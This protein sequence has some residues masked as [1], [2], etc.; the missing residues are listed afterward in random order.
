LT[1]RSSR[2]SSEPVLPRRALN[3]TLLAR[4]LLLGRSAMSPTDAL[5]HLVGLQAQNPWSPYHAL[6]ARLA[7]FDPAVLSAMVER[8]EA[9]RM[10]LMRGTI[11]LVLARDAAALRPVVQP[12]LDRELFATRT[13]GAGVRG[14]DLEPV[15]A[16]GRTLVEAEPRSMQSLRGEIASRWPELDAGSL[17]YAIRNLL[18]TIQATPRGLWRRSGGVQLTTLQAWTGL[19]PD[20]E[21]DLGGAIRRH[22]RAFGPAAVADAAAWSR[23]TGLREAFETLRPGLRTFRD[24]RGRELF[25]VEDAP[26]LTGDEEA[27]VRFLPDYDNALL[28]HEDR[29]RIV[30]RLDWPK[31]GD[32]VTAPVFL[33]DGFVAGIW[34]PAGK[35]RDTAIELRPMV[36]IEPRDRAAIEAEAGGLLAMIEPAADRERI[37]WWRE[38]GGA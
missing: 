5:E 23:L 16:L 3:R 9:V 38:G 28:S 14:V 2:R 19:E 6:H 35:G 37:T 15:L 13:W 31:L 27:P 21:P 20:S 29:S 10:V 33:V 7:A 24:E 4:Q 22:L 11:H 18:P 34:K 32:N 1:T 25:D 26:I 17:A 36:A 12:V 8:R 30:P